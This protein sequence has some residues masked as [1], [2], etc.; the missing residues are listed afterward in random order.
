MI[1]MNFEP[2]FENEKRPQNLLLLVKTLK[3][4]YNVDTNSSKNAFLPIFP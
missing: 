1:G 4:A 3:K 2:S